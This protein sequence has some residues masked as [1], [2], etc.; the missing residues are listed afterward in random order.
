M[1]TEKVRAE[2][3]GTVW[4]IVSQPGQQLAEEDTILIMESMKM[5]IPVIAPVKG[6]LASLL[7]KEGQEVSEGQDVAVIET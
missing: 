1:A 7:V 5:E 6:T 3:T 2:I 4:K